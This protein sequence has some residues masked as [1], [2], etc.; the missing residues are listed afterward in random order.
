M[1]DKVWGPVSTTLGTWMED[2]T[3]P[4]SPPPVWKGLVDRRPEVTS[5]SIEE[6]RGVTPR[7]PQACRRV[8]R[9]RLSIH[10]PLFSEALDR[11]F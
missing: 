9:S 2:V 4:L 5:P 10:D 3:P 7:T 8:Y 1:P 11:A 6:P